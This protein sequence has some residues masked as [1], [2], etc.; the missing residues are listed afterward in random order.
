MGR[1]EEV[2]AADAVRMSHA[3]T[4]LGDGQARGVARQHRLPG[5]GGVHAPEELLLGLEVLGDRLDD[6]LGGADGFLQPGGGADAAGHGLGGLALE[7][8]VPLQVLG[9]SPDVV[10][11]LVQGLLPAA[12]EHRLAAAEGQDQGDLAAHEAASDDG[13]LLEKE[14][15]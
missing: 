9:A 11:A 3:I 13:R 14:I 4:H 6:E 7:Q 1:L 15:G 2:G 5:G 8:V 10:Q 12:H